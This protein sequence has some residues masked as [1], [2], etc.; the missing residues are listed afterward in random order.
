MKLVVLDANW[1]NVNWIFYKEWSLSNFQ[2]QVLFNIEHL[3]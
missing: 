2:L 1:L 3:C